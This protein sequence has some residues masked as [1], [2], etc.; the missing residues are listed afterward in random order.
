MADQQKIK[1]IERVLEENEAK[2]EAM[3]RDLAEALDQERRKSMVDEKR[4]KDIER[5]LNEKLYFLNELTRKK[6]EDEEELNILREEIDK[7]RNKS[8]ADEA[9]IRKLES[10]LRER[11][12]EIL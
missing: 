7:E 10:L 3:L 12:K 9:T 4:A 2:A 1:K 6:D 11:E 8:L 5:A